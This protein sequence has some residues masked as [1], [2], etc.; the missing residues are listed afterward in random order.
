MESAVLVVLALLILLNGLLA[1]AEVAIVAARQARLENQAGGGDAMARTAL[2]VAT[3]PTRSLSIIQVGITSIG[4]LNG[5]VGEAA[6]ARPLAEWLAGFG[7]PAGPTHV[8]VTGLVVAVVTYLTIVFGELVP[9]RI[10]QNNPEALLKLVA[11]PLLALG[12]VSAPFVR[13]LAGSTDLVLKAFGLHRASAP[14]V[15]QD[16]IRLVLEEGSKAGAI[17]DEEH[18][19]VRNVFRLDDRPV[20]TL[21]LPRSDIVALDA[22]APL[23]ANLARIEASDHARYPVCRGGMDHVVGVL[24]AR[25]LLLGTRLQREPD[26]NAL[27]EPPVFVPETMGGIE[28]LEHFR[29]TGGQMAFVVD[30]YG[31]VQ[32]LVTV[33]DLVE[34][35]AGEFRGTPGDESWAVERP[36]GSWLLDGALPVEDLA[37][38][39]KLAGLP[40]EGRARFQ[41]L[42]GLLL[43]LLGRIPKT[44][45]TADWEQWRFEVM[46]MDGKRIDKV[47]ASRRPA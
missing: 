29:G 28:L 47:L 39:L 46:D 14:A 32:G 33:H 44:G 1:M 16:E 38:R 3:H 15:T 42:G 35:I 43:Y 11:G 21:M 17:E 37:D 12:T 30:E 26:L 40:G 6:F 20:S 31:A 9:K 23:E 45:E 27:M 25:R 7:L 2:A 8:L 41:T 24:T 13:L 5:I 22:D 4:I 36:D 34:A 19:M 18:R 10:G